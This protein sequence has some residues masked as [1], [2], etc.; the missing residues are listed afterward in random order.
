MNIF[1]VFRLIPVMVFV[2]ASSVY[3]HG[4]ELWSGPAVM[5]EQLSIDYKNDLEE[6]LLSRDISSRLSFGLS[7]DIL[8]FNRSKINVGLF[9]SHVDYE[10]IFG[11]VPLQGGDPAIPK[12]TTLGIDYLSIPFSYGF[13]L[14]ENELTVFLSP[15]LNTIIPMYQKEKTIY[16]DNSERESDLLMEDI[17]D[18]QFQLFTSV[19]LR[20]QASDRLDV[21]VS[22]RIGVGLNSMDDMNLESNELSAGGSLTFQYFL[23][24]L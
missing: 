22:P 5:V 24:D 4:Q 18:F 23:V 8:L 14:N 1:K 9:L 13:P 19:D 15:G 11:F 10:Y 17:P 12:L 6:P 16:A 7:S 20:W 3:A 21:L 2:L